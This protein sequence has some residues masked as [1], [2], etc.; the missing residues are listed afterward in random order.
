LALSKT[1]QSAAPFPA[2]LSV[3]A[4]RGRDTPETNGGHLYAKNREI[5]LAISFS[6]TLTSTCIRT[7][8][9]TNHN[10][11]IARGLR[12]KTNVK[13]G[14]SGFID[15]HNQIIARSL[16]VKSNVK[17]GGIVVDYRA[18]K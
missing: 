3:R 18:G 1:Y 9:R 6:E 4:S 13:A 5:A 7:L 8:K 11:T 12:V 2:S 16:K 15:N 17:A 10:Q 14:W